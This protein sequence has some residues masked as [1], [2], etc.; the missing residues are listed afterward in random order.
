MTPTENLTNTAR[1]YDMSVRALRSHKLTGV[2]YS[3]EQAEADYQ[4]Q[5]LVAQIETLKL[6][7]NEL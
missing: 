4:L 5:C 6:L 2:D 7:H 3:Q 1:L